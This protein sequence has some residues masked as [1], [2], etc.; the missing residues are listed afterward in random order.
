MGRST[1]CLAAIGC[2]VLVVAGADDDV[3]SPDRATEIASRDS[4]APACR[5]RRRA[6]AGRSPAGVFAPSAP[7]GISP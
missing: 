5:G 4:S 7:R 2:P 1:E 6:H 3:T